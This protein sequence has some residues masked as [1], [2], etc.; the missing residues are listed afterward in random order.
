MSITQK[1]LDE[2]LKLPSV[3][4][5]LPITDYTYPALLTLVGKSGSK[6]SKGGVYIFSHKY[7][8]KKY[9][10]SS[11]DLIRRFKQY[12]YKNVLFDNKDT[13]LLLPLIEKEGLKAFTL[14]V[15]VVP[16]SY[17]NISHCFLEQY[18]LLDKK[19]NLNSHRIVNF[20][21]NQGFKIYLYNIDRNILYYSSSSL[22]AFCADLG[23]HSSSYR[24]CIAKGTP[25]VDSF[26]IS[27][28][29]IKDAVSSNLTELEVKE[30][31]EKCRKESLNKL[32]VSYGKAV[33]VL[34]KETN[35]KEI[36]HSLYKIATKLGV[37]RST[38]RTY[39]ANGKLYKGRYFF[40]ILEKK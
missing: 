35:N 20:R 32:F 25:F 3:K 5:D 10:G 40:E 6:R 2:L 33:E 13:G 14:E 24:K 18:Y 30:L 1:E 22:N 37:S 38:V 23:I 7:T 15:I 4:F 26:I 29:L 39:I 21:V 11:N 31:I 8:D 19:F 9:V 16:S 28:T 34:D 36:Y 27:N 12:F 17:S